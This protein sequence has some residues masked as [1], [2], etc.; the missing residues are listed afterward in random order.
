MGLQGHVGDYGGGSPSRIMLGL[1]RET[2]PIVCGKFR[3]LGCRV[4]G[5]GFREDITISSLMVEIIVETQ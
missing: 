5:L 3:V 4:Q 2:L 1:C